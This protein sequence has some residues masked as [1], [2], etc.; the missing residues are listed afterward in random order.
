MANLATRGAVEGTTPV[1]IRTPLI[2]L[3][4]REIIELGLRLGVDYGMTTSCYDPSPNGAACGHCDAC[5]LR[6]AAF[7]AAGAPDPARYA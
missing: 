3:T 5:Q 2:D 1:R 7:A 6:L 4:K